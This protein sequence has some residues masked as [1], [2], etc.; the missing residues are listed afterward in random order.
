MKLMNRAKEG[1]MS[2]SQIENNQRFRKDD[3]QFNDDDRK[4][5]SILSN[6]P[7]GTESEYKDNPLATVR[8]I[9]RKNE[10]FQ[11]MDDMHALDYEKLCDVR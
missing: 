2:Q 10:N 3:Y 11:S 1:S 7:N 6:L 4:L 8:T 5:M 9:I